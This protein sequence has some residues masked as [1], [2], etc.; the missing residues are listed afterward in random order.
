VNLSCLIG[1]NALPAEDAVL[2]NPIPALKK[3]PSGFYTSVFC[4]VRALIGAQNQFARWKNLLNTGETPLL[5]KRRNGREI[6]ASVTTSHL[7]WQHPRRTT[8]AL[9]PISQ[10]NSTFLGRNHSENREGGGGVR[11]TQSPK[12]PYR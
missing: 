5:P 10:P 4:Q 8:D 6:D 7:F 9:L 2:K 3:K 11:R 12:V 1:W